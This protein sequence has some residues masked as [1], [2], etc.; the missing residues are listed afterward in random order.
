MGKIT[1]MVFRTVLLIIKHGSGKTLPQGGIAVGIK[2][3]YRLNHP[4]HPKPVAQAVTSHPVSR[5]GRG[6]GTGN[7]GA[8]M[9]GISHGNQDFSSLVVTVKSHCAET[10]LGAGSLN[11]TLGLFPGRQFQRQKFPPFTLCLSWKIRKRNIR[12]VMKFYVNRIKMTASARTVLVYFIL[13][14]YRGRTVSVG[15]EIM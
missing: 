3:V 11:N 5:T 2:V 7:R 15:C 13:H 4:V 8:Q 10:Y 9:V 1:C 6:A 14:R 12:A